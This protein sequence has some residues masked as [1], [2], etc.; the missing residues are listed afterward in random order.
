MDF[1]FEQDEPICNS[2]GE[3]DEPEWIPMDG[4]GSAPDPGFA[5]PCPCC[6]IGNDPGILFIEEPMPK[7]VEF[8]PTPIF[9]ITTFN[10]TAESKEIDLDAETGDE[11]L[12][13]WK[14]VERSR[15][16]GYYHEF[17]LAEEVVCSDNNMNLNEDGYYSHAVIEQVEPG[18]YPD[19]PIDH[20]W[21]YKW[22]GKNY[23]KLEKFN[24]PLVDV[25]SYTPLG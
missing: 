15:C 7:G 4:G 17:K 9:T 6:D 5:E 21:F 3:L 12:G 2:P 25:I 8:D 20:R 16:V 10:L 24:D 1:E 18:L 11:Q 13:R 22:D 19:D 14:T 23:V